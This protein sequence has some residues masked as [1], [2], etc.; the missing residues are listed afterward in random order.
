MKKAV[1]FDLDGTLTN[2]LKS[3]WKSTNM[4]LAT[5]GLPPHE[6]DSYKYFAGNG[7]K[8]LIRK[9]LIADGDTELVHFDSVMEAYNSIFEEYCM[10]EVKPYDGIPELLKELKERGLHLAVNSNKPQPRTVDVVEQ[11]FG[12]DTFDLLV[13][14]CEER[15]RKPAPDGVNYILDKL[16]LNKEDVLY[17]GDTCTDMQTGKSAGVF[18]VGALWG[19]R[20]R[21][22]LTENHADAIIEKPLELLQY[23]DQ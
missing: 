10:Y 8:E 11:I 15:K 2:T 9:S 13:G 20:D 19:F 23:I 4:A 16:H 17:I 21:Q 6:I 18:T 14:Q 12:K 22:E 3:L 7:A 5:A 1:I